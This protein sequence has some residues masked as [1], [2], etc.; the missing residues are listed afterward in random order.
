MGQLTL[1]IPLGLSYIR[2]YFSASSTLTLP[3]T[4]I[5]QF[6]CVLVAGGG[7][8]A[9]SGFDTGRRARG[10]MGIYVYQA[11]VFCTA[12][13]T[14]T[15]TVGAGGAGAT[16]SNTA[17]SS[18]NESTISGIAGNGITTSITS[19]TP[20]GGTANQDD[21][22]S[23]SA[24]AG[25]MLIGG[26]TTQATVSTHAM[27]GPGKFGFQSTISGNESYNN[28]A[29]MMSGTFISRLSSGTYRKGYFGN[30][31]G[32]S[33]FPL[34]GEY[35]H[36]TAGSSGVASNGAGGSSTANTFFAGMGGG[37][38]S[39]QTGINGQGGGGGGGGGSNSAT[40]SG[41]GGNGAANSGGGGGGGG[42]NINSE[43]NT[44]NGGNGGSGFVIIGYWG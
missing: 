39:T 16:S 25:L 6:D 17:G 1:P 44:G 13:T 38:G 22:I 28:P 10:G 19:G 37:G 33:I 34:L 41:A 15:I 31:G 9:R 23:H 4:N 36:A 21:D 3:L 26:Q 30:G 18:G 8:G 14:L 32:A 29:S 12:G 5:N 7:G 20:N 40:F 2:R 42:I 43:N 11:N 24:P 35:L 27:V